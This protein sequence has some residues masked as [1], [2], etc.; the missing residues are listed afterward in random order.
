MVQVDGCGSRSPFSS[1]TTMSVALTVSYGR[2]P[3]VN[4]SHSVTP[5]QVRQTRR[6][7][8]N[9]VYLTDQLITAI[10]VC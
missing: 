4:S 8:D 10:S 5:E 3:Y 2:C 6:R 1:S 9:A 7:Y